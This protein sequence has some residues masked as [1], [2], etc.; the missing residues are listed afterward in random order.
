MLTPSS[1]FNDV[2]IIEP[3][4]YEDERG[5]FME[6]FRQEW[7]DD[8]T[9][10]AVFVQD[11]HSASHQGVL[12]GLHYQLEQPQGKLVRVVA[13]SVF[14]VIVD[15]RRSSPTFGRWQG[16]ELSADNRHQLWVPPGFAHGFYTRSE[17]AECLYRCSGYFHAQS[18]RILRWDDADLAIRWPLQGEPILSEKD[19]RGTA[20][21]QADYFA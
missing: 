15:M 4:L 21:K 11:N 3:R 6:T 7:L 9:G 12:R 17:R 13:G 20:F 10:G 5:F 14:D 2:Y 8:L 19:A 18:E 16:F 1:V